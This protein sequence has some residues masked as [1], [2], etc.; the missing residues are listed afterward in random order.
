LLNIRGEGLGVSIVIPNWEGAD[1]LAANLPSVIRAASVAPWPVEI[2]IGHD[3]SA[4]ECVRVVRGFGPRV[5]L[6]QHDIN[7]GFGQAVAT[8]AHSARGNILV[9]LNSDVKVSEGFLAP[10][11]EHFGDPL[12]FGV[13]PAAESEQGRLLPPHV[14]Q[15]AMRFGLLRFRKPNFADAAEALA[16][17]GGPVPTFFVSGGHCALRRDR[18]LEL[19]G[20]DPI[21]AP[22]YYEDTDLSY[23]AWRR[24][25]RCWFDP[26]SRVVHTSG[27]TIGRKF[28]PD[29]VRRIRFRNGLL[30]VW[31]NALNPRYLWGV[32]LPL[33]LGR[34]ADRACRGDL[35]PF[36]G[37]IAA[38]RLF[39]QAYRAGAN[40]WN[41]RILGDREIFR[42][43]HRGDLRPEKQVLIPRKDQAP[44]LPPHEVPAFTPPSG[45]M[46]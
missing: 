27:G 17:L 10:L 30:I 45:V 6:L 9:L 31:R 37:A 25:W 14:M 4:D 3:G 32:H 1:V 26:R 15:P 7:R 38:L 39:P 11:L 18:F 5:R 2:L 35:R 46:G 24:G 12:T 33:I 40:G 34:I 22:F 41:G 21:F 13:S 19:G 20:F 36:K 23:R 16:A 44:H 42:M 28:H 8:G 43:I 29:E